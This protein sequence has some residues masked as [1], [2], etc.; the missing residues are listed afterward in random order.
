MS[1]RLTATQYE[2]PSSAAKITKTQQKERLEG[3]KH[4]T[5]KM[6]EKLKPGD[7]VRYYVDGEYRSGGTVKSNKFPKY[8]VLLNTIKK[9]SW[10]VQYNAVGLKIYVKTL[11]QIKKETKEK[12]EIYEKWKDGKLCEKKSKSRT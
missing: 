7:K 6:Y 5:S 3:Y 10:C 2:G 9:L 8:I 11:E 1:T 4:L 12:N